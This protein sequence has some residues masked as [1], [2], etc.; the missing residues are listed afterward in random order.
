M[1]GPAMC[2]DQVVELLDRAFNDGDLESVLAFYEEDACVI[3]PPA[4]TLRGPAQ[5]RPF[6]ERALAS[7]THA[8]QLRTRV[9]EADGIALFLSHWTLTRKTAEPDT[10]PQVFVATTVFRRQPDRSWKILID[11][12]FGPAVLA[13]G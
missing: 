11:N 3:T 10:Q 2:P 9:F 8:T 5:L 1:N 13:A 12:P 6:F 4:T 7:G